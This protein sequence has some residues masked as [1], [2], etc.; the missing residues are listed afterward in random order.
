M[1]K[2]GLAFPAT[3]VAA[4][5]YA[6]WSLKKDRLTRYDEGELPPAFD[7]PL[8]P[9]Y[10]QQMDVALKLPQAARGKAQG[11]IARARSAVDH[12]GD[13]SHG[14]E[15]IPTSAGGVPGEWVMAPN[16][17]ASGR[18][19][20]IH[21]G[22][23]VAGSPRS[24]RKII[25]G[26]AKRAGLAVLAIDYRL[27]PENRRIHAIEDCRN[28]YLWMTETGP[29]GPSPASFVAVAGDSAGGNLAL[30]LAAWARDEGL[31]MPARIVALAPGT[32]TGLDSPSM[33]RNRKTDA[34]LGPTFGK[35]LVLPTWVLFWIGWGI[36]RIKPTDPRLSPLRG[37]LSRLP[38]TLLQV[39]DSEMLRDDSLRYYRKTRSSGSPVILQ[40]WANCEHAFQTFLG[41]DVPE[42]DHALSLIAQFLVG[43]DGPDSAAS[44]APAQ[45]AGR[46]Q[47]AGGTGSRKR[48]GA[49]R[50]TKLTG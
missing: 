38:P 20:Y 29:D 36:W 39:S 21:G 44:Q 24:H 14:V 49:G 43:A 13:G 4:W 40:R 9:Q 31:R 46:G 15:I 34:M 11:Q 17:V 19:L 1:L 7:A 6:A 37:D 5:A 3:I 47:P 35:A 48:A 2:L 25:A 33:R 42:A 30:M 50:V 22:G 12:L 45:A 32:D 23:F 26:I 41:S 18:L 27:M 16:S 10:R 28:A 8:S